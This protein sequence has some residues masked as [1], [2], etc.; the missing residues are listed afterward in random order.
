AEWRARHPKP[1]HKPDRTLVGA[2]YFTW[3]REGYGNAHWNDTA[4][5][6]ALSD[7]PS[8]G[9]YDSNDGDTIRHHL[10]LMQDAG[11]D[12]ACFNLHVGD[13]GLDTFQLWGAIV[14][15]RLAQEMKLPLRFA[16]HLCLYTRNEQA[17]EQ[18]F[19]TVRE[20]FLNRDA[21]LKVHDRPGV[22]VL[23]SG[24]FDRDHRIMRELRVMSEGTICIALSSLG[25]DPNAEAR[26]LSALFDG[27][28][29]FS[30][31]TVGPKAQ[32]E[33][34]WQA[35]YDAGGAMR[36]HCRVMTVSP[37]CDDT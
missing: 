11:L 17:I 1:A 5:H 19:A 34:L 8:I 24:T 31:L 37:G 14:M 10:Q 28:G 3:Y 13:S 20:G 30:P 16:V 12:F 27:Y 29:L 36:G 32:L 9:F 4:T 25:S 15:C 7:S 23:W 18:A 26:K 33:A 6:G 35:A 2:H 22:F 21:A